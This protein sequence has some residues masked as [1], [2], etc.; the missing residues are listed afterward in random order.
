[1][2]IEA[3]LRR[4]EQVR[5]AVVLVKQ[6]RESGDQRLVAYV[7]PASKE[8]VALSELRSFLKRWLPE[9]M[10]PTHLVVMSEMPLTANGKID[11]RALP[12]PELGAKD[13]YLPAR[14][15]IEELVANIW[16]EVVGVKQVGAN[17]NFFELGGHSLLATRI[18]S[19]VREAFHLELP[20]RSLFE[21][22]TVAEFAERVET[23]LRGAANIQKP[24]IKVVSRN[25]TF[26][27]SSAQLR[28]WFIDQLEPESV[29]YTIPTAF[30]VSGPLN[31]SALI[32][33]FRE[34]VR[35]HE[36]LRTSFDVIDGQPRQ[37]I[38]ESL[39]FNLPVIDLGELSE[40][41][42]EIESRRVTSIELQEPFNLS[43]A[44]LIR[45]GLIRLKDDEHIV[46]LTLHHIVSDGWSEGVL[47]RELAQL[48]AAFSE[49]KDSPLAELPIQYVDYAVWQQEWLQG[50]VL[51]H[52]L[53]YWKTQLSGDLSALEL[54]T[55]RPR[56]PV[57]TYR[58]DEESVVLDQELTHRLREFSRRQ[59]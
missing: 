12:D 42:R 52:Q 13:G 1:G 32:R 56:P 8:E 34:I 4:H 41:E 24:P 14:T 31:S 22:P 26:P 18:I 40:A 16:A 49:G 45:A 27:L 23:G 28:F 35:R 39:E 47:T 9:Y 38:H 3:A 30:R 6:D 36:A 44:P 59:G 58:G 15:S 46:L 7:V 53:A 33:A 19:R 37:I 20:V 50:D 29:I 25:R 43:E 10:I 48:Y 55:D 57:Q 5:K 51:D 21:S 2:E 54:P 11:K 17:D